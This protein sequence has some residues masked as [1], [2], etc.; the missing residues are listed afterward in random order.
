MAQDRDT[1]KILITGCMPP[2]SDPDRAIAAGPWC[3]A[4]REDLFPDFETKFSFAPEPFADRECQ[5]QAIREA[6]A[7]AAD[8]IPRLAERLA[9]GSELPEAYWETLLAPFAINS[10]RL[11]VEVWYRIQSLMEAYGDQKLAVPLAPEKCPVVMLADRDIVLKGALNP[12]LLHWLYSRLLRPVLPELWHTEPGQ[13]DVLAGTADESENSASS[14]WKSAWE[15]AWSAKESRLK[16]W[17]RDL[18]LSLPVP[19]LQGIS[20]WQSLRWSLAL[21][22]KSRLPDGSLSLAGSFAAPMAKKAPAL[23]FD[24]MDLVLQ[25]LPRTLL[26]MKHPHN[27][28]PMKNPKVRMAI[29][30]MYEDAGYRQKLAIWRARGGR[31]ISMQHGGNYGM[32]ALTCAAEFVEYS[33]H[34]FITWG[35][36]EYQSVHATLPA[37]RHF[38]PLPAPKLARIGNAWKAG[39][40]SVLFVG[41]EIASFSYQLDSHPTPLE[42]LAYRADKDAFLRRLDREIRNHILYRPYFPTPGALDDAAWILARYPH[43]HL[44]SGD[45]LPKL[46]SCRLLIMDHHG[47]VLLEAMAANVPTVCFWNEAHWPLSQAFSDMLPVLQ[48]AGIWHPDTDKAAAHIQSIWPSPEKWWFSDRVQQARSSFLSAFALCNANDLNRRWT[49]VLRSL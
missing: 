44:C 24:P 36:T 16:A 7:L 34:A 22:H 19:P 42:N 20:L 21:M 48:D 49:E 43:M 15:N 23:P 2:G 5:A 14:A 3:F 32:M 28:R 11:I 45:L 29:I 8:L 13:P 41:T 25:L 9:P 4:G 33:Q 6:E 39:G 37:R 47:T 46:L 26:H 30:S 10:A 31:L 40:S 1:A 35:W 17:L 27:V 12:L 18:C 38:I